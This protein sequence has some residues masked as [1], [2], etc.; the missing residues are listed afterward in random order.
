MK[1]RIPEA[2]RYE[3]FREQHKIVQQRIRARQKENLWRELVR[4]IIGMYETNDSEDTIIENLQK[5]YRVI[6]K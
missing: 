4:Y 3:H 5:N 2:D 1:S 6:K